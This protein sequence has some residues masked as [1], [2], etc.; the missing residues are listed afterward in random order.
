M[1][2]GAGDIALIVGIALAST[3][4]VVAAEVLVLRAMRGRSIALH[5]AIATAGAILAIVLAT[6]SVMALMYVS[7]HDLTVF[8]WITGVSAAA[9]LAAAWLVARRVARASAQS[10]VAS[11]EQIA[12]GE[13][14]EPGRPEL[15]EFAAVSEELART[16]SRLAEARAEIDKLDGARRQFLAWIS[17]DLRTPLAGIRA[18]SEAAADGVGDPRRISRDI[19][20]RV[21]VLDRMVDDLFQLSKLETGTLVLHRELV[22]LLDVVSDAVVDVRDAA[23]ARGIRIVPSSIEGRMLWADPRELGRAIGNLLQNAVRHAPDGSDIVIAAHTRGDG[24][25]VISV[26]DHGTGVDSSDLGRIFDVGWRAADARTGDA[27][28]AGLGLAIV[29]GIA[30]AHGGDV[31]AENLAGGFRLSVA[32]PIGGEV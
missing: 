10:L 1:M 9:S 21:D 17:H 29:R 7:P 18:L 19:Q 20:V 5:V 23:R 4:V 2:L 26:I 24:H 27:A 16:S 13:V 28:G 31:D 30:Q 8:G 32:L 15:R 3:L 22:S 12:A 6:V 25:L 14:V 11:A